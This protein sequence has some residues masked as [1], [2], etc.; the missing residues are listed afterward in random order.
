MFERAG[1][2]IDQHDMGVALHLGRIV[3][4]G[5]PADEREAADAVCEHLLAVWRVGDDSHDVS[6]LRQIGYEPADSG[7]SDISQFARRGARA[8]VRSAGPKTH[9]PPQR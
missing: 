7:T 3:P 4:E 6:T 1:G 9:I 5:G 2:W 8:P